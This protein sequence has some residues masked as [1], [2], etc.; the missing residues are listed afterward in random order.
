MMKEN[1]N[2]DDLIKQALS[3]EDSEILELLE[4]QSMFDQMKASHHG[5]MKGWMIYFSV[6]TLIMTA[7]LVFGLV[8]FLNTEDIRQMLL[9]GALMGW[10]MIA[11]S[12][13]KSWRIMEMNKRTLMREIKRLELQIVSLQ[14]NN[15]K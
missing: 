12:M 13:L 10:S 2:I 1:E 14:K 4:E 15:S 11:I 3:E 7:L 9:W 8:K 5:K 6:M